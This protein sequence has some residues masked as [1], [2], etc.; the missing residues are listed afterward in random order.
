M[1]KKK[2]NDW[3]PEGAELRVVPLS[4]LMEN[5]DNAFE[6]RREVFNEL[7][8]EIRVNGYDEPMKVVAKDDGM[9]MVV[10]GNHRLRALRQLEYK[11]VAVIIRHDWDDAK[12]DV[13]TFRNN[14]LRGELNVAKGRELWAKLTTKYSFDELEL[15]ELTLMYDERLFERIALVRQKDVSLAK[16]TKE[17][18]DRLQMK[19]LDDLGL[20]LNHLVTKYGGQMEKGWCYFMFGGQWQLVVEMDREMK[21]LVETFQKKYGGKEDDVREALKTLLSGDIGAVEDEQEKQA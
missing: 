1:A 17:K 19:V 14:M 5:P 21:G 4:S 16:K 8:E 6:E 15:R 12:A 13:Q 18:S 11:E 9:F 3:L 7:V 2:T 10:C 20:M